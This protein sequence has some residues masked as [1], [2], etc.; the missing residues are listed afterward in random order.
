MFPRRLFAAAI[1]RTL[2]PTALLLLA[3]LACRLFEPRSAV[4]LAPFKELARAGGCADIRNRLFLIDD[5]WVF[6]DRAGHCAD[7]AYG[8][9]LYGSTPDQVL[10]VSHDS[11]AGPVKDCREKR[12]Q[13]MFDTMIANLDKP[14]LG[15]GTEHTVQPVPVWF[16]FW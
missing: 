3:S 13:A 9:T 16:L 15:L 6:W 5:Q 1:L 2:L 4:D 12:Y 11:I 8:E 14:A 10:C 7:A